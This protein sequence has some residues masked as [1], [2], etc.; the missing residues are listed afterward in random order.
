M[1]SQCSS[2]KGLH[3]PIRSQKKKARITAAH[4]EPKH[5]IPCSKVV[6]A[7]H[8]A[9]FKAR[10]LSELEDGAEEFSL[11]V[12]EGEADAALAVIQTMYTGIPEGIAPCGKLQTGCRLPVLH[13]A[14]KPYV[15]KSWTGRQPSW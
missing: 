7:A 5:R 11:V 4:E 2:S 1:T 14:W 13:S 6:L 8:S 12:D 3:C 15:L 9:Y 10:L